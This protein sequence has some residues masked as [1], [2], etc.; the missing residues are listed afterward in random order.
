[1]T[2]ND[3]Y[4][5]KPDANDEIREKGYAEFTN[6]YIEPSGVNIDKL[7]STDY[8]TPCF[9]MGDKGTGKTALLHYLENHVHNIDCAASTSYLFFESGFSYVSK[10]NFCKISKAISMAISID[11]NI[12]SSGEQIECDYTYVWRWQFYQKIINDNDSFS[13]GL[14]VNDENWRDFKKEISKLNKTI[15]GGKM[16]IP[17]KITISAKYESQLSV[18]TPSIS[19]EPIDLSEKNFIT[20]KSYSEFIKI[21]E[22]ADELVRYIERTDIPYYIFIDELEAYRADNETFYRDLRMIRDLL[23]TVKRLNDVFLS[24]TKLICSVRLEIINSINRF[25]QSN[26]L[27]KIM[28]GFDERLIWGYTNTNS[29]KHPIITILLKRIENAEKNNNNI[30]ITKEDIIEKWFETKV[31][32]TDICAYILANTWHKPRDIVRLILAVQSKHSKTFSNFNQN[33]FDTSMPVYSKQCLVE[34]KEE[35]RAL[36]NAGEIETIVNCLQGYKMIFTFDEIGER[37][38]R[39]YSNSTIAKN[40]NSVLRDIYRIGLIGNYLNNDT[41]QRW[42]YKEHYSLIIDEPWKMIIHPSLRIELSTSGKRDRYIMNFGGNVHSHS[43]VI[44]NVHS[45]SNVIGTGKVHSHSNVIGNQIMHST[46]KY[47]DSEFY[48]TI[49]RIHYR[50]VIVSFKKDGQTEQGY[51]SMK[52]LGISSIEQGK[53]NKYFKIGDIVKSKITSYNQDYNNWNM[54]IIEQQLNPYIKP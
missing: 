34:V 39:L 26:Q 17:V 5:G 33:T 14:F 44:G 1:M 23:F 32:N 11:Q 31:Y 37:A 6:S 54:R 50:Y 47:M 12:A 10:A 52:N 4:A 51:I 53:I 20:T 3:I 9:I 13:E 43:N 25:V 29:F 38:K 36:Y 30:S 45:H 15:Y 48:A 19:L 18:L 28:Q 8:G 27:H 24:G 21:I 7:L 40:T 49:I 35:M 22:K 41:P 46:N 2:L 42:H 16:R